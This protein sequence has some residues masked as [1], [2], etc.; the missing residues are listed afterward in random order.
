MG[1]I[2]EKEIPIKIVGIRPGEKLYEEYLTSEEGTIATKH[3]DVFISKNGNFTMSEEEYG[4]M[5]TSFGNVIFSDKTIEE[6]EREIIILL[7]QNVPT[8]NHKD[9]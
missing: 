8:F 7:K 4:Q 3:K 6:K 5:I 2:P 9:N 1:Y